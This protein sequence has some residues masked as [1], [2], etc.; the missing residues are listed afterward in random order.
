MANEYFGKVT[1]KGIQIIPV[2]ITDAAIGSLA[3][4]VGVILSGALKGITRGFLTKKVNIQLGV[5]G[6][7]TNESV[8]IGLNANDS[9]ISGGLAVGT[10]AAILDPEATEAYLTAEE[11]VKTVW[12]ETYTLL[13]N[14]ASG[15]GH[16]QID[17]M[18]SIGGGKG[19]P[20]PAGAGPELFAFNPTG[21]A[22]TTGG[23]VNGV[24]TFY[25]VWLE[26]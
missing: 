24:V 9:G 10:L 16:L 12:H 5:T 4:L 7:A 2:V 26:D 18:L 11:V 17:K 14:I 23:L 15:A 13:H 21:D 25:G 8:L 1:K 19:I 20:S 22:L 3:T 6:L